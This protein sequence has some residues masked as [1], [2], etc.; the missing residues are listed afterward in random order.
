MSEKAWRF[1]ESSTIP[2]YY[3]DLRKEKKAQG[4]NATTAYTPPTLTL[5]NGLKVVLDMFFEEG[6]LENVYKRHA[7]NGE[8]TRAALEAHGFK[9][10][11][12]V[13]SNA[14]TG[15]YLPES[16]EGGGK[17]VKFMR[18]Q[19]GI[20][21]AGGQDHLKGRYFVCRTSVI[22]THLIL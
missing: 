22:M 17:F 20:T 5:I 19:V 16:I 9:L 13:P 15:F 21:Y 18:E 3:L 14:A 12:E 4:G 6:G 7:V 2:R 8:A 11:A 10:L 1:T